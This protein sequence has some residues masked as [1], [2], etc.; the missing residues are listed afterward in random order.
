MASI[1][2]SGPAAPVTLP[3]APPPMPAVSRILARFDRPQVEG[4]IAVAIELLDALDGPA[5]PDNP[6]YSPCGD[7]KPGD[8]ADHERGG[9]EEAAAWI[10]WSTM[11]GSQKGWHNM[12]AGEE[13]D[14]EDDGDT[15]VEDHPFGIDPEEDCCI[16][17]DDT[18]RS[19]AGPGKDLA[20]GEHG[21]GDADDAEHWSMTHNV[22]VHH[23]VTLDHNP[24]TDQ[25]QSLGLSNLLTSFR[26]NG[27]TLRS[28]DSGRS[29]RSY[30]AP[31][32]IGAPV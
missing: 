25:R 27:Q 29:F 7:G 28:A 14:E 8:A 4:F 18:V 32:K 2:L 26:T 6:D 1:P 5:D 30:A 31:P 15:G 9:D 13:D 10:E 23:V 3:G 19:G 17:G 21:P 16:A 11:R 20:Y 22:P 24:F 12:V